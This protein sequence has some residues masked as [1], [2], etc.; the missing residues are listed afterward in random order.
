MAAGGGSGK[1]SSK[2]AFC[3]RN[4]WT[5][6]LDESTQDGV[7]EFDRRIHKMYDRLVPGPD[8]TRR[9]YHAENAVVP[10]A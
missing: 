9:E 1:A 2:T 3:D 5:T 7:V 6:I 4:K 10:R 8:R